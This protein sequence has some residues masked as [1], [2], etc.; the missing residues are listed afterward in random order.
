MPGQ[1]DIVKTA[2]ETIKAPV[3]GTG[4]I[5]EVWI[6]QHSNTL[7]VCKKLYQDWG[8]HKGDIIFYGDPCWWSEKIKRG[9]GH[10]LGIDRKLFQTNALARP[11][12]L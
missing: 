12:D 11:H 6:P 2:T 5:G 8:D 10:R 3:I 7:L 9:A 1:F 4:I